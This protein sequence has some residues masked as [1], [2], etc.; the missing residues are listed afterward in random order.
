L[1]ESGELRVPGR[2]VAFAVVQGWGGELGVVGVGEFARE[3]E[4][5]IGDEDVPALGKK[6]GCEGA[7]DAGCAA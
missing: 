5:E 2:R 4:V 1:L 6:G 3:R 7:G